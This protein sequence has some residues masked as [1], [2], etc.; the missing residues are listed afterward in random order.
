M[1]RVAEVAGGAT[2][3]RSPGLGGARHV[4]TLKEPRQGGHGPWG[5]S[6]DHTVELCKASYTPG[7]DWK[8]GIDTLHAFVV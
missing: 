4:S 6:C 2:L 8:I 5:A 1:I 3:I 7:E